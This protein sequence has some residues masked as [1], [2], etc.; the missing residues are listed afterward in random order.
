MEEE[1]KHEQ[2]D[3]GAYSHPKGSSLVQNLSLLLFLLV[4]AP[5]QN[6]LDRTKVQGGEGKEKKRHERKPSNHLLTHMRKKAKNNRVK[7]Q[8]E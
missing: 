7:E 8:K 1:V 3:G 2:G 4:R 6:V 5:V